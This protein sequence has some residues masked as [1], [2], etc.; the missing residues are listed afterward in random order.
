MVIQCIYFLGF[1][2]QLLLNFLSL[3]SLET[4][5]FL[6]LFYNTCLHFWIIH[7][8]YYAVDKE[9]TRNFS[10]TSL[11]C[12]VIIH[13]VCR[14]NVI[15]CL[16]CLPLEPE[17]KACY[18]FGVLPT[19]LH[20][21]EA[22]IKSL[23]HLCCARWLSLCSLFL[24]KNDKAEWTNMGEGGTSKESWV[25]CLCYCVFYRKSE[26]ILIRVLII[27]KKRP[28]EMSGRINDLVGEWRRSYNMISVMEVFVHNFKSSVSATA[29][30]PWAIV[31]HP[32]CIF[33]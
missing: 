7:A 26:W 17:L 16:K 3:S 1:S 18:L 11:H 23:I 4:L 25:L 5:H 31:C 19:C 24:R 29:A 20:W 12:S 21:K 15:I 22:L 2:T 9:S 28:T 10:Q 13:H 30:L 33:F 32:Y 14:L 27:K 6:L 8:F